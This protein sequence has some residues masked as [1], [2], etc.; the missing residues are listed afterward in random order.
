MFLREH[1]SIDEGSSE[2]LLRLCAWLLLNLIKLKVNNEEENLSVVCAFLR[3]NEPGVLH[4]CT[5]GSHFD[6]TDPAA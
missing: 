5:T 4:Y 1:F 3:S 2:L 6:G